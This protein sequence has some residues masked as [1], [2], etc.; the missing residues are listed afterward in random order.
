MSIATRLALA[1]GLGLL[2]SSMLAPN[3]AAQGRSPADTKIIEGYQ[4]T[5]PM[6]RKVLPALSAPGAPS[7]PRDQ[8]DPRALSIAEMAQMI[9][10]CPPMVQALRRAGVPSR[11]AAIVTASLYRTAEAV[12]LR[13]GDARAV[14]PGPLRDNALLM[15]RNDAELKRLMGENQ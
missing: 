6:L 1:L 3:A 7:C 2:P 10:R 15:Q 11:E 12:A 4:L 5:M 8:R 9:E 13:N 14:A